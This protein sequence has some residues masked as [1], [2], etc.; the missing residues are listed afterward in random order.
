M[1]DEY[2]YVRTFIGRVSLHENF[3]LVVSAARKYDVHL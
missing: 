1:L 2:F 3:T